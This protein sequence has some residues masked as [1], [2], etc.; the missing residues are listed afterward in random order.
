[1]ADQQGLWQISLD[2]PIEDHGAMTLPLQVELDSAELL[3]EMSQIP[4][5][6]QNS[7]VGESF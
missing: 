2:A 3:L 4:I 6:S 7:Q 1:M 5:V